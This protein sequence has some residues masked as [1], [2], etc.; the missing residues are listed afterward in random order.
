MHTF[1]KITHPQHLLCLAGLESSS[2]ML[3]V[4]IETDLD[5]AFTLALDLGGRLLNDDLDRDDLDVTSGVVSRAESLKSLLDTAGKD[6]LTLAESLVLSTLPAFPS[7]SYMI[8]M[9]A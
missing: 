5:A 9:H 8:Y 6:T 4:F 7:Y 3:P 1:H 2:S